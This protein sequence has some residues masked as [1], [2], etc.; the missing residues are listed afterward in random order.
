M[1]KGVITDYSWRKKRIILGILI[2]LLIMSIPAFVMMLYIFRHVKYM[3]VVDE[4]YPFQRIYRASDFKLQSTEFE[5]K[6][7]DGEKLWCSEVKADRPKGV[8]IY[9][10]AMKEPSVTFFYGH[11]AMMQSRGYASF[12]LEVRAHGKS[13]G[14]KLGLGMTEVED[15]RALV[16]HIKSTEE[17]EGLPIILQ[18]VSLGGTIA[19]TATTQIPEVSGCIAMS[20]FASVDDQ[21]DLILK[22]CYIPAFLRAAQRPFTHQALRLFYGKDRADNMTPI[23]QIQHVGSKTVL[24]IASELD[25]SIS[26]ENTYRLQNVAD[27]AE[28]WVRSGSDHYI[29]QDNDFAKVENDKEY[30]NYIFGFIDKITENAKKN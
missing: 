14:K 20:P 6:T 13:S 25:E 1:K 3:G 2:I 11:A 29:V 5:L 28:F 17:Y 21:I 10:G 16:N 22:K 7:E 26:A 12:L 18:G 19:I 27:N 8:M 9:L 30:C 23:E 4:R 24:V 15:V